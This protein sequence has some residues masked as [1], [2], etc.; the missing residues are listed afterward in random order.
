MNLMDEQWKDILED[1]AFTE[2]AVVTTV[3]GNTFTVKGMYYSGSYDISSSASYG[4]K[5]WARGDF[6]Q[7]SPLSLPSEMIEP[8]K[9]L[10]NAEVSIEG[11]GLFRVHEVKGANSGMLTLDIQPKEYLNA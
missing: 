3:F 8:T 7:L 4:A 2:S 11:R 6:F 10:R 9:A 1:N 5:S